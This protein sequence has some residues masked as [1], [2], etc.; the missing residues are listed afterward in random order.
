MREDYKIGEEELNNW[1]CLKCGDAI[2]NPLTNETIKEVLSVTNELLSS[3]V[4]N[5]KA[6]EIIKKVKSR[7]DWQKE[8]LNYTGKDTPLCR[9]CI[10][11][12]VKLFLETESSELGDDLISKYNFNSY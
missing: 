6:K 11:E 7:M 4:G 3:K 2:T 10:L 5:K 1:M 12:L 9:F 8:L